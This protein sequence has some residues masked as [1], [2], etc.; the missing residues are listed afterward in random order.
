MLSAENLDQCF[1]QK[2]NNILREKDM[3]LQMARSDAISKP[4][5]ECQGRPNPQSSPAAKQLYVPLDPAKTGRHWNTGSAPDNCISLPNTSLSTLFY[6]TL[7]GTCRVFLAFSL[8]LIFFFSFSSADS[9]F[10]KPRIDRKSLG[11]YIGLP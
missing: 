3:D 5:E 2:P 10:P 1:S 4:F 8:S 6:S 9:I 11:I 7:S